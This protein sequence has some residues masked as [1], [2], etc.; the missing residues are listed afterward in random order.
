MGAEKGHLSVTSYALPAL[1]QGV[2]ILELTEKFGIV[3]MIRQLIAMLDTSLR[4]RRRKGR[5]RPTMAAALFPVLLAGALLTMGAAP[6]RADA[7]SSGAS[8]PASMPHLGK[9]SQLRAMMERVWR[10]NPAVQAAKAAVEASKAS[11]KQASQPLYNPIGGVSYEH[12]VNN[13]TYIGFTQSVDW[14][15]KRDLYTSISRDSLSAARAQYEQVRLKTAVTVL[16]TLAQYNM[17]RRVADITRRRV[18]L[19]RRFADLAK[20]RY[21]AGDIGANSVDLARLAL[22]EALFRDTNAMTKLNRAKNALSAASGFTL[23]HWPDLPNAPPALTSHVDTEAL[24]THLPSLLALQARIQASQ[25]QIDLARRKTLPDPTFSLR[26]G[27]SVGTNQSTALG[28]VTLSIPL[29][30]RRHYTSKVT[31]ADQRTLRLEETAQNTYRHARAALASATQNYRL[32]AETWRHWQE[33][34]RGSL[35]DRLELLERMWRAGE[36]NA[37]QYLVQVK[38]G[39]TTQ[40]AAARIWGRAWSAWATWLGAA[41][42]MDAWVRP[43]AGAGPADG[44]T[45]QG[46]TR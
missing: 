29:Y 39:L 15:D 24:V 2:T 14:N 9:D 10:E 35:K 40:I 32:I 21:E 43:E 5:S 38:Q 11:A 13:N 27:R 8:S 42:Q 28:E 1:A 46:S 33:S 22:S 34:G 20:R 3:M 18:E 25:G 19:M 41:G 31:V 12:S 4:S 17:A 23:T 16:N 45:K 6:A 44:L 37:T 36:L 7:G 30:I 26:G